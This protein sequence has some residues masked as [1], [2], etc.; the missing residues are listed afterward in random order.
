M[1]T[2]HYVVELRFKH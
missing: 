1:L 2:I